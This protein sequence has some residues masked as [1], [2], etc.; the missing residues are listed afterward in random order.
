MKVS[1]LRIGALYKIK[2]REIVIH[3]SLGHTEYTDPQVITILR[4]KS[5]VGHR[6]PAQVYGEELKGLPAIYVG[7]FRKPYRIQSVDPSIGSYSQKCHKFLI[8]KEEIHIYG[9]YIRH[10]APYS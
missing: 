3:R 2:E 7:P 6:N 9:E 4:Q 10:I 1:E 8:G 5:L